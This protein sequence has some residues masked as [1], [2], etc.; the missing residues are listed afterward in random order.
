MKTSTD[1]LN[2]NAEDS[3]RK[4]PT[5]KTRRISTGS[6]SLD[7]LLSGGIETGVITEFYGINGVGK[8]QLCF[9]LS[10][11]ATQFHE[12][13]VLYIDTE[14]N[15]RP[16]RIIDI[17]QSRGLNSKYIVSN[18]L[19]VNAASANHQE[20]ILKKFGIIPKVENKISIII[21]DS[22]IHHFRAAQTGIAVVITNQVNSGHGFT[23]SPAGGSVIACVSD[24]RISLRPWANGT[25]YIVAKIVKS[26]Y[27]PKGEVY[28]KL[29]RKGIEDLQDII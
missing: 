20:L 29:G 11:I 10:V 24:Y 9:T 13:K 19:C 8:T 21:V 16:E 28:F 6:K 22:I 14:S 27:H 3:I 7:G 23:I 12:G 2:A 4:T 25:N 1:E 15:F 17:A 18:I 5:M 26:S